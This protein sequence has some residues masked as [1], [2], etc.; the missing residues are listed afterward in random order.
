VT[1]CIGIKYQSLIQGLNRLDQLQ[2]RLLHW[3]TA[4][5]DLLVT[6]ENQLHLHNFG[7]VEWIWQQWVEMVWK[8]YAI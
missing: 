6:F 2:D 4:I 8:K 1:G 3:E 5:A 7:N